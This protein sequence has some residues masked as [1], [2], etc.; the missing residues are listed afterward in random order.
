MELVDM[1]EDDEEP[2]M[3]PTLALTLDMDD[4]AT[5][6]I[7]FPGAGADFHIEATGIVTHSTTL[8]PDADG[9]VDQACVTLKIKMLGLELGPSPPIKDTDNDTAARLY[10]PPR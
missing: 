8:D 2:D 5:L 7:E 1:T 6:G 10:G 4:L 3:F 9:D